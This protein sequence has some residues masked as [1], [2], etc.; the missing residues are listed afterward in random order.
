MPSGISNISASAAQIVA[1]QQS[2]LITTLNTLSQVNNQLAMKN[3]DYLLQADLFGT[4]TEA[5]NKEIQS[6]NEFNGKIN[7]QLV[8]R[9][10]LEAS[11]K[12]PLNKMYNVEEFVITNQGMCGMG[13]GMGKFAG[14]TVSLSGKELTALSDILG[15]NEGAQASSVVDQ[16]TAAGIQAKEVDVTVKDENGKEVKN[17]SKKGVE[18]TNPDGSKTVV[19][20]ANGN[21]GLDTQDYNFN[22]ALK[23]FEKDLCD[24]KAQI[25]EIDTQVQTFKTERD[26]HVTELGKLTNKLDI[27]QAKMNIIDASINQLD[28]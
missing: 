6:I 7:D 20:D 17:A 13:M 8:K 3:Q 22:K 5:E 2:K 23:C 11:T 18:I 21:G 28:S 26:P 14:K 1:S 15:K 10:A 4:T 16:L 25:K 12:N 19:Y 27:I 24:F 9:D